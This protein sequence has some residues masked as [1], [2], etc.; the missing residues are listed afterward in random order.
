MFENGQFE[1]I[2]Q[3]IC[4]KHKPCKQKLMINSDLPIDKT[5]EL[6]SWAAVAIGVNNVVDMFYVLGN[7]VIFACYMCPLL[8]CISPFQLDHFAVSD[9]IENIKDY[10]NAPLEYHNHTN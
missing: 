8:H 2:T 4:K 6:E 3:N 5:V 1:K 7:V 10:L 9:Y